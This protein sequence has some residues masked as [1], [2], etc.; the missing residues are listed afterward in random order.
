[1]VSYRYMRMFMDN[2]RNG[3][4]EISAEDVAAFPN[5]ATAAPPVFRVVPTDMVSSMHMV[6]VM[7][8]PTDRLRFMVMGGWV[9]KDMDHITFAGPVGT[10]VLGTFKVR[11][12]G[13][14][15]TRVSALM[16]LF[17]SGRHKVHANFGIGLPSGS[18]TETTQI[19]TPMGTRPTVRAPF[20][21]QI[22]TGTVDLMPTLTYEGHLDHLAWGFQ[23]SGF[24]PLGKND[25]GYSWGRLG[26]AT[27]WGA[28]HWSPWLTTSLSISGQSQGAI[29]GGDELI[30]V[31]NPTADPDNYGGRRVDI[32]VGMIL[33]GQ[34][35]FVRGHQVEADVTFP[36]YQNLN[37]PQ[38]GHSA[39]LKVGYRIAF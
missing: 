13:F 6:G 28:Y 20:S 7:Y 11:T 27:L 3:T 35:G 37:G 31:P 17:E 14:S 39:M 12:E 36:L 16:D 30:A 10:T 4:D 15:D 32:G 25:A 26:R 19:L 9:E 18:F 33:T 5:T 2:L 34:T 29:D 8:S 22:G 24:L 1:M 21:M 38:L 23:L